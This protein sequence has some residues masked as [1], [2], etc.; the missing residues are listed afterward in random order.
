[1]TEAEEPQEPQPE[2]ADAP[3]ATGDGEVD[4]DSLA[5]EWAAMAEESGEPSDE[6]ALAAEWAA[7]V[8]EAE[9]ASADEEALAAEW[10][11]GAEGGEDGSGEEERVLSQE[12]IDSL[13]GL[14]GGGGSTE[15]T[16]IEALINSSD[17]TYER[18][19]MLEVVFDRL[20]RIMSTSVRNFTSEN[21]DINL[22]N[23]SAQRFGDY[24]NSVPLPAMITVFKAIEWDNYGLVTADS[25]L[26]YSVVDVL[27]GGRRGKTSMRIEGRP[28]TTIE[29]RLVERLI[30]LVLHDL[31]QAFAPIVSI[32]FRFERM[33]TNPRFAAIARPGNA[34]VVFRMRIEMEHR[35][36]TIEFLLPYATLEPARDVLLQMFMGEKFGRDSIWEGHLSREIWQTDVDLEAVLDEF[37]LDLAE[38]MNFRVGQVVP[39]NARPDSPVVLRSGG[40]PLLRARVG[41]VRNR[42][43][44]HVE[45]RLMDRTGDA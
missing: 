24:L 19:P 25:S 39:L 32:N 26:I 12:E 30:R 22:E 28:Y 20:E 35:S 42:L 45:E 31:A 1:M 17:V 40:V 38:V 44:V 37:P 6:D 8:E 23:I 11:A 5:A 2:S 29:Q 36:G 13:L 21:V 10:A 16:G 27:L 3:S 9:N 41:K 33:E 4:Q 43:A 18:L 7:S 14:G 15:R 34:C